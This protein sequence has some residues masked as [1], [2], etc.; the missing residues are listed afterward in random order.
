[1]GAA[2]A[3]NDLDGDGLP[4]DVVFVDTRTDRVVVAPVP[5]TPSRLRAVRARRRT[6]ALRSQHDGA[7]GL[8][9]RRPERG[10]RSWTYSS[11]IGAGRPIAFLR[12]SDDGSIH[13]GLSSASFVRQEVAPDAGR[14][15]TNAA[16]L[17]D[18]DGDGH[19][20]LIVG[21]Y[22]PDDARILDA[23]AGGREAMQHSM[24]RADNGGRKHLLRWI[25]AARGIAA[26]R[27][28]RG[29]RGGAR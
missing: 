5:G 17:A 18:L 11:I 24:S 4:N 3:L 7:D 27:P 6:A 19:A 20:D 29:G 12:R 2:V 15:F 13:A 1:M 9:A 10:W 21:N 16:T 14:W 28:L 23:R 8:L 26:K 25:G 22:F